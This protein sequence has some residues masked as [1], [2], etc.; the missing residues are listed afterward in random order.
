MTTF[1]PATQEQD[2]SVLQNIVRDLE[3]CTLDS[4]VIAPD[5]SAWAIRRRSSER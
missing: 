5:E 4:S 3:E 1:D 2:P